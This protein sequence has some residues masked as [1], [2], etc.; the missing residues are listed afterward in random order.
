MLQRLRPL[1]RVDIA[2]AWLRARR[3]YASVVAE[4]DA[5]RVD[6]AELMAAISELRADFR[7]GHGRAATAAGA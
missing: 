1:L 3:A 4:R 2:V 6:R 5:L 7:H